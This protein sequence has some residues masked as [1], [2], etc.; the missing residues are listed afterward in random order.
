[1]SRSRINTWAKITCAASAINAAPDPSP[2]TKEDEMDLDFD[3]EDGEE[4]SELLMSTEKAA[5]LTLFD[6]A[7]RARCDAAQ[8][9]EVNAMHMAHTAEVSH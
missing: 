1:M 8:L 6:P 9:E 3:D 2:S 4:A 7:L 5:L